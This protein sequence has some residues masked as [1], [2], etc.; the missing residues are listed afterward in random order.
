MFR[1]VFGFFVLAVGA[2]VAVATVVVVVLVGG[3]G[4]VLFVCLRYVRDSVLWCVSLVVRC[5]GGL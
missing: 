4:G 2:V 3:V 1:G 5:L